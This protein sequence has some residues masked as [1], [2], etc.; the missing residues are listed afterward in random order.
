MKKRAISASVALLL[1]CFQAEA[2][3]PP[4]G[5]LQ[6][7][8]PD[9]S[10]G[11]NAPKDSAVT[12]ATNNVTGTYT[13]QRNVMIE[14]AGGTGREQRYNLCSTT[15]TNSVYSTD[16]AISTASYI[17]EWL[18]VSDM[19]SLNAFQARHENSWV[20]LETVIVDRVNL[21]L[22]DMYLATQ[23]RSDYAPGKGA[24]DVK[25]YLLSTHFVATCHLARAQF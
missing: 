10:K 11:I 13:F 23:E 7:S 15:G 16:C 24:L 8:G 21:T 12:S 4:Q 19:A 5:I 20:Q 14:S 22:D 18:K 17:A 1:I 3:T 2:Q 9:E 25:P 6:C